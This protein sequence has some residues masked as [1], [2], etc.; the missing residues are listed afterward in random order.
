ML[1]TS[2]LKLEENNVSSESV[3][4]SLGVIFRCFN[5]I[6]LIGKVHIWYIFRGK[7]Y[8]YLKNGPI[9]DFSIVSEL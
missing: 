2:I 7:C 3:F 9:H 6:K 5:Y 8:I 1:F 4:L